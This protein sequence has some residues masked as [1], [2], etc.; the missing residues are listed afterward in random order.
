MGYV[1]EYAGELYPQEVAEAA[2]AA[3]AEIT[4]EL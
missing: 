4:C 3:V 1:Y 2:A